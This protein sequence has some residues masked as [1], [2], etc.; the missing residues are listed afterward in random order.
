VTIGVL[1]VSTGGICRAPMA[2]G[3][4]RTFAVRGRIENRFD[5]AAAG[6]FD[7]HA[8]EPPSLMAFEVAERRGY[9]VPAAPVRT[10][11]QEDLSRY[12]HLIAMDRSNLA[13]LRWLAPSG[14]MDAPKLLMRHVPQ[15]PAIDIVDPY[16]GTVEDYERALDLIEKGC[17][18]LLMTIV[19]GAVPSLP[20]EIQRDPP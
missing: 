17:A 1:F 20:G 9:D 11:R 4:F 14:R 15:A 6:T 5:I 2:A 7:G 10:L 12:D 16:G 19:S 13:T 3:V 8:G 18:G